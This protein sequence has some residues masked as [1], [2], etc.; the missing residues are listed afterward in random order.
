M[1]LLWIAATTA[2][3][4]FPRVRGDVPINKITS[5]FMQ[6]FS[7]RARGCSALTAQWPVKIRVFPA[8]A[9]M[10]PA[11]GHSAGHQRRFPRVRGD[12]PIGGVNLVFAGEFSPR[13]RGCSSFYFSSLTRL[14]VFPACAGMFHFLMATP[15]PMVRFPR[16]RGDVPINNFIGRKLPWFSPR[17]RGCSLAKE[18]VQLTAKGFPRVRGDVPI[19]KPKPRGRKLFSPRARGCSCGRLV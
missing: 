12:V 13:A 6:V 14:Y 19:G 16:V 11:R 8:C 3:V 18:L 5:G 15:P 2:R 9:G 7:P 17:A 10:F 4:G 1:F